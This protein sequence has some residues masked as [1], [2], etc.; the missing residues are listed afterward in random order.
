MRDPVGVVS[1]TN[2]IDAGMFGSSTLSSPSGHRRRFRERPRQDVPSRAVGQGT[3]AH[4][5]PFEH[6]TALSGNGKR[7][8]PRSDG[9]LAVSVT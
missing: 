9:V 1:K 8:D 6:G 2:F 3:E 5:R 7:S 4:L